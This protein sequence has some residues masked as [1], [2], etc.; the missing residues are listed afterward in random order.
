M[1]EPQAQA[2]LSILGYLIPEMIL[3]G[4]ACLAFL[5][6]TFRADR[7]LWGSV[8]LAGFVGAL[9]ALQFGPGPGSSPADLTIV[10][11]LFDALANF[12][13]CLAWLAGIL[14][15][16]FSWNEVRDG[17][18]AEWHACLLL[19]SAGVGLIGASNDLVTLFLALEMVSIPT[20][21]MLYLPRHDVAA[22]EAALKYFLLSVFSSA[23][24]LFGF[25]Y[26][27]GIAGATNLTQIMQTLNGQDSARD[28]PMVAA[29]AL[30]TIVAG[31]GFRVTAAPF[32][33]YAPDVYQGAPTVGA[34]LLAWLPKIAGF[35]ALLRVLGFVLPAGVQPRDMI[36]AALSEQTPILFWFL[37]VITMTWGNILALLQ[38]NIKRLLAYSS[39]AHAGYMLITL[40]TAGYLRQESGG[41]DGVEALLYYLV[42]YGLMTVGAFALLAYLHTAERPV[43]TADDLAGLSRS[44][45]GLALMMA[46]FLFSLIGIPLTAGFAGKLLIFFGAMAVEPAYLYWA[47]A[48]IGMVNAAIGGWYYLRLIAVMYLR[49]PLQPV[50]PRPNLPG[51]VTLI[52]C[53]VLTVGLGVPPGSTWLLKQ[54][55]DAAQTTAMR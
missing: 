36:G 13:R 2:L 39:V 4:V 47:L 16:L 48:L 40:A 32:H 38:D 23:L 28:I 24:V 8:A 14:F 21:V 17:Q 18:A 30:I 37:A 54:I 10:P 19:V 29:I 5:G 25:S 22:Q 50:T 15:V 26:V 27:Y 41:A 52:L 53:A 1:S 42:A 12:G 34:A 51:L 46:I 3:G 35:V 43:E 9:A 11:V 55:R 31:L 6:A 33:F 49:Q 44:H 20:Y 45:P 7:H